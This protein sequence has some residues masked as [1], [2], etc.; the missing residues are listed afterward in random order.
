MITTA[1]TP[2][3]DLR[4]SGPATALELA[5]VVESRQPPVVEP[6]RGVAK[7]S[8]NRAN[9]AIFGL[10]LLAAIVGGIWYASQPHE[11][12]RQP[13]M[14]AS[15]AAPVASVQAGVPVLH[16]EPP[17]CPSGTELQQ[18]KTS[19]GYDWYQCRLPDKQNGMEMCSELEAAGWSTTVSVPCG[20][21]VSTFSQRIS[22]GD[23]QPGPSPTETAV[24]DAVGT[25]VQAFRS[26]DATALAGSY[27][28]VVEKYF[29]RTNVSQGEIRQIE[30]QE[31]A[32]MVEI[33][34]YEINDI[35]VA[36]LPDEYIVNGINYSRA[37][38]NFRKT[39]DTLDSDGKTF[40]GEEIEQLT[41][42]SSPQGWKIVREEELKIL[43]VSRH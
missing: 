33:R 43:R 14:T 31:F 3:P 40:A 1:K 7:E 9:Y 28:P 29:L 41:F 6:P 21:R 16:P 38:A 2:S 42:T 35:Q 26:K 30:I 12:L 17:P 37:K 32:S 4:T 18:G 23:I 20:S 8:T 34:Q 36:M 11:Q 27:A 25:W 10:V 15:T 19:S 22:D 24:R 5:G 13:V 39:W